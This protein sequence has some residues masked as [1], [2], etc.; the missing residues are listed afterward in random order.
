MNI[1]EWIVSG[2]CRVCLLHG[3]DATLSNLGRSVD[4]SFLDV[5][6]YGRYVGLDVMYSVSGCC[7]VCVLHG[8][9]FYVFYFMV[10]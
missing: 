3:F 2:C 5:V 9:I 1:K 10:T 8:S 4:G 7:I 6:W